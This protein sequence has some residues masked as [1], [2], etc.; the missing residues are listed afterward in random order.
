MILNQCPNCGTGGW[1]VYEI[2]NGNCLFCEDDSNGS[3]QSDCEDGCDNCPHRL[4]CG[5]SEIFQN[6]TNQ[7]KCKPSDNCLTC[8]DDSC[9]DHVNNSF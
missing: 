9:K 8:K 2:V 3:E 5:G 6:E 4:D 7:Q 1:S